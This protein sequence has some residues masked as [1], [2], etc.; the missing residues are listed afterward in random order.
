MTIVQIA[1]TLISTALPAMHMLLTYD[2]QRCHQQLLDQQGQ[3]SPEA[4]H[5]AAPGRKTIFDPGQELAQDL[6][7]IAKLIA[8]ALHD[9]YVDTP[10]MG[11][12][13]SKINAAGSS[14]RAG[15][16]GN[17]EEAV[18]QHALLALDEVCTAI[19]QLEILLMKIDS[20]A[21]TLEYHPRLVGHIARHGF[22]TAT[23]EEEATIILSLA[24]CASFGQDSHSWHSYDGRELGIPKVSS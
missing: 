2:V 13:A 1:R 20:A 10:L 22:V 21:A 7:K 19:S 5:G 15:G 12:T 8:T 23:T 3:R 9:L 6:E 11:T 18:N 17:K 16:A 24:K 4:A 14:A